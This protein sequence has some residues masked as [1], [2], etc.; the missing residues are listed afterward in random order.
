MTP[1]LT[2]RIHLLITLVLVTCA[3]LGGLCSGLLLGGRLMALVAAGA[4]GLG[5]WIGSRLA[6]RQIMACVSPGIQTVSADGYAQGI[7]DAVVVSIATYRA[8]VFPLVPHGVTE[9]ERDARRT[10]AYRLSAFDALPR[11]VQLSAAAALE[12]IDRG[13]DAKQAEAAMKGLYLTA[14][15]QRLSH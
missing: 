10:L 2:A 8:A 11:P 5:A 14:Y 6:R 13:T 4:A 12:A 1:P 15:E 3:A 7:A 9:E